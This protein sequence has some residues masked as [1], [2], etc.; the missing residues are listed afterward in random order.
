MEPIVGVDF[1]TTNSGVAL[2]RGGRVTS[3]QNEF[4]E[5]Y[6][7][8][9]VY[10]AKGGDVHVGTP[11]KNVSILHVDSTVMS[12]KRDVGL[13]VSRYLSLIHI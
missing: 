13:G 6:I 3:L 7:P 8:S 12:V 11:A 9:A 1:G 4:G 2:C 10:I 5:R